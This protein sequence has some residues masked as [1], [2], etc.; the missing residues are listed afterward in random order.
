MEFLSPL[1]VKTIILLGEVF[2]ICVLSYIKNSIDL[3]SKQVK[4]VIKRVHGQ[5]C[6]VIREATALEAISDLSKKINHSD[7]N[8]QIL[9]L[10]I[11]NMRCQKTQESQE[12]HKSVN[13]VIPKPKEHTL[14]QKPKK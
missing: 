6:M 13:V 10:T 4:E 9:K 14:Q 5:E 12:R 2:I 8:I 11:D 1:V 3:L 7:M